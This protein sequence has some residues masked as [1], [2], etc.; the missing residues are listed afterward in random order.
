MLA[1]AD[2]S[3][4]VAADARAERTDARPSSAV[5]ARRAD[6]WILLIQQ[7]GF[8]TASRGEEDFWGNHGWRFSSL[9][10]KEVIADVAALLS[11][12]LVVGTWRRSRKWMSGGVGHWWILDGLAAMGGQ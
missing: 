8:W 2:I 6:V 7:Y 3:P 5:V 1:S 12:N 4:V 10:C 9:W 11:L